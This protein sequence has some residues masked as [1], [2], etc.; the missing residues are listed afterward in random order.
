MIKL[1]RLNNSEISIN[2]ELIES[3]ESIP[4][5][6][7]ILITG[8]KFIVKESVEEVTEKVREYRQKILQKTNTKKQQITKPEGDSKWI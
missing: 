6:K 7:I 1:H 5:T 2:P 3:I 4:D 8:N